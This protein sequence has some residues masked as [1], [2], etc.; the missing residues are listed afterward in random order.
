MVIRGKRVEKP[1]PHL[2]YALI[3]PDWKVCEG[4]FISGY[5]IDRYASGQ[6]C[7]EHFH[8]CEEYWFILEGQALARCGDEVEEVGAGDAVYTPMG[9]SHQITAITD[10]SVLWLYGELKG[11]KRFG[12]LHDGD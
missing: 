3:P 12:H 9:T 2:E 7:D 4:S 1:L 5:G 6:S 11:R 8:D 10:I